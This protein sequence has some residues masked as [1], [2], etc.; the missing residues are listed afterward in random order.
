MPDCYFCSNKLEH[1]DP[2]YDLPKH[3]LCTTCPPVEQHS[4]IIYDVWSQPYFV[5]MGD[6]K[7]ECFFLYFRGLKVWLRYDVMGK[8]YYNNITIFN[9]NISKILEINGKI[10]IT[11]LTTDALENKIKSWILLS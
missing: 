5:L 4:P 10:D 8:Y 6:D 9:A 7:I 2:I 1:F 11:N 3:L